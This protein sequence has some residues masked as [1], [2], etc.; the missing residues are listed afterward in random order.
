MPTDF[1]NNPAALDKLVVLI[2]EVTVQ[3][4]FNVSQSRWH[5]YA[6]VWASIEPIS[7]REYW[8]A[9]QS[10]SEASV[11]IVIRYRDGVTSRTRV[12]YESEDG[13]V[14]FELKSPPINYR[15]QNQFLELM[16]REKSVNGD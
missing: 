7:G 5:P 12:R 16:C 11:R 3:D 14:D 10:Q 13:I 2:K 6:K 9:A 4:E 1:I 15:E 8:N